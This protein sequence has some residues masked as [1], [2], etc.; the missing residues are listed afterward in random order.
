MKTF[1]ETSA[2]VGMILLAM[3]TAASIVVAASRLGGIPLSLPQTMTQLLEARGYSNPATMG[4]S[5]LFSAGMHSW[6]WWKQWWNTGVMPSSPFAPSLP[7][8]GGHRAPEKG[9]A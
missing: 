1:L 7:A 2:I 3:I 6:E 8:T 9:K 4:P 5:D